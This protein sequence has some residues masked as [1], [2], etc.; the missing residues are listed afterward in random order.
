MQTHKRSSH[1][2]NSYTDEPNNLPPR[3]LTKEVLLSQTFD[4]E[5]VKVIN[6]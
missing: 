2:I 4:I 5:S 3:L 6:F 1:R